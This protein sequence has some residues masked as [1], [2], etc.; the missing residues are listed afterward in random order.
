MKIARNGTHVLNTAEV[1]QDAEFANPCRCP[2]LRKGDCCEIC[3]PIDIAHCVPGQ[4]TCTEYPDDIRCTQCEDPYFAGTEYRKC[5][6]SHPQ[7]IFLEGTSASGSANPAESATLEPNVFHIAGIAVFPKMQRSEY[8]PTA[9]YRRELADPD[10]PEVP[11]REN[12]CGGNT[13]RTRTGFFHGE[14]PRDSGTQYAQR[15]G[16]TVSGMKTTAGDSER[17]HKGGAACLHS[18]GGA[19]YRQELVFE[20]STTSLGSDRSNTAESVNG[21]RTCRPL[22]VNRSLSICL[23]CSYVDDKSARELHW[24]VYAKRLRQDVIKKVFSN[25]SD[26]R[27]SS[28][29]CFACRITG[30]VVKDCL[31]VK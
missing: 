4:Q 17:G 19:A 18:F 28:G 25:N 15:T 2:I 12:Q 13:G 21:P 3:N 7:R 9:V 6:E 11:T 24:L 14:G 5:S 29:P 22:Y 10:L 16:E 30:H 31:Y 26:F 8:R 1:A 27:S 23:K 20:L